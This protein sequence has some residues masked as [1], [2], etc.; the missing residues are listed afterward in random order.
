MLFIN[1]SPGV[2]L[3]T[4]DRADLETVTDGACRAMLRRLGLKKSKRFI[5]PPGTF[6]GCDRRVK[7]ENREKRSGARL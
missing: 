6:L 2:W 7:V 5:F 3:N 4:P 1:V